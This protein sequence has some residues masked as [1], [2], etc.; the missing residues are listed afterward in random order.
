MNRT[1]HEPSL[2]PDPALR[3]PDLVAIADAQ[4]W[5]LWHVLA[6]LIV[7]ASLC[8]SPPNAPLWVGSLKLTLYVVITLLTIAMSVRLSLACAGSGAMTIVAA[9]LM[10]I[11]ILNFA[12]LASLNARAT[13]MLRVAGLRVGV[14][15]A[16]RA[17]IHKLRPG[18]CRACGYDL[19]GLQDSPCPEC[20][21]HTRP[22]S[23]D[24]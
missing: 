21:A 6:L 16:P 7:T 23:P 15:G 4:R 2:A 1:P 14:M 10:F 3:E 17:E 20:G 11:P 18:V 8:V 19:S 9:L 5:L 13:E 12:L 22:A 24:A